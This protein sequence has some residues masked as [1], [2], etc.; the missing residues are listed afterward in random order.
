MRIG[1]GV[2][3]AAVDAAKFQRQIFQVRGMVERFLR[4]DQILRVQM[5]EILVERVHAVIGVLRK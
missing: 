1:G 4:G 5:L 3:D 2:C